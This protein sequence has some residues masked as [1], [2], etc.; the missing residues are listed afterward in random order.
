MRLPVPASLL[1]ASPCKRLWLGAAGVALF[2]GTL[3]IGYCAVPKSPHGQGTVGLDFI[4]FYT[5]G[6]FVREGRSADLYDIHAVQRFQ[7]DLARANGVDLGSAV[8]PYW[9]PPFYAWLFA[10]LSRL[11]YHAALRLWIIVNIACAAL[12]CLMLSHMLIDSASSRLPEPAVLVTWHTWALVPV[13]MLLSTPFIHAL[14]HAQNTCTS[15]LLVTCVTVLWRKERALAAGLVCGLLF[16]KPQLGAVLAAVLIFDQG[17][18]AFTGLAVTGLLLLLATLALPGSLRHFLHQ[19]PLNLHFVQCQVP[20]LWDRHVT[21]KAFWR[22]LLQGKGAGEPTWTVSTLAALSA[23]AVGAGLLWAALRGRASLHLQLSPSNHGKIS[24]PIRRDRLI[25]ATIA[26]TPLLMPFYFDYDQLLLAV[27][28]VLLAADLIR[29]DRAISLRAGDRWLLR[30]W[31]VYYVWLML[32]PDIALLTRVN[33]S[34]PLLA[35][36][37]GLLIARAGRACDERRLLQSQTGSVWRHGLLGG[38]FVT[39]ASRPC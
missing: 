33:L 30:I 36:V 25:A 28:A 26:A 24:A 29:R 19:V 34:V 23:A 5:A 20:Y 35:V 14:S 9:N 22:L 10:P 13:L 3:L 4:A 8:G 27:P 21:F 39:R 17:R 1:Q 6:T 18:R 37:A 7:G 32:N 15:L 2:I 11:P 16:Y 12:A 38:V 31:P